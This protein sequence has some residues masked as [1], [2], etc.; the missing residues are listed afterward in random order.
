MP[1]RDGKLIPDTIH[2]EVRVILPPEA[3]QLLVDLHNDRGTI[4]L[5]SV[6]MVACAV[7]MAWRALFGHR[8]H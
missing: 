6:V 1:L 3:T 2:T 7:I 8:E 5:G 4:G